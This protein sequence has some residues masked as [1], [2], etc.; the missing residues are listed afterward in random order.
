MGSFAGAPGAATYRTGG[1]GGGYPGGGF[2]TYGG[3]SF[4]TPTYAAMPAAYTTPYTP[5]PMMPHLPEM[6]LPEFSGGSGWFTFW[7]AYD[8]LVHSQPIQNILKFNYLLS[9]LK[10]DAK[11]AIERISPRDDTYDSAIEILTKRFGNETVVIQSLLAELER[12]PQ[13]GKGTSEIRKTFDKIEGILRELQALKQPISDISTQ[14]LVEQRMP[15]SIQTEIYKEKQRK[16]G[17]TLDDTRHLINDRLLT[18]PQQ[19]G[20]PLSSGV[21]FARTSIGLATAPNTGQ[22]VTSVHGQT[23][24][25]YVP[26]ACGQVI[27]TRNAILKLAAITVRENTS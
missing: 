26:I 1:T 4:M 16:P 24:L 19:K 23:S 20:A 2:P 12:I 17:W 22:F 11:R 10:G 3:M 21:G 18:L 27:R 25:S 9:V 5:S 13:A 8:A 14:R 7:Q 15:F 6:K